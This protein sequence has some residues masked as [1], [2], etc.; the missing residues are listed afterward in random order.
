MRNSTFE[1]VELAKLT[2]L[3]TDGTHQTPTYTD[4]GIPFLRVTDLTKSNESKK[5]ISIDEHTELTKRCNPIKGDILYSKNGTIGVAKIIDWDYEFSIFVS[6]ALL[7]P[8]K[9]LIIPKYLEILLNSEEAL[10]RAKGFS[11]SGTVTNLHLIDIKRLQI[12]LPTLLI[13]EEIVAEIEGYQK[14]IDGAK[15]VVEN[16]KPKIDIDPDWEMVE[17]G[18]IA[19][20]EYGFTEKAKDEGDARFIRITDIGTDGK[21]IKTDAKYID[22]TKEA[23]KSIVKRN[24][25]LLARTGATYGKTMIYEENYPAVF[26]SFLMRLNFDTNKVFPKYYWAFAQSENYIVQAASLMTGGGQPQFNGNA[27]VKIKLPLPSIETQSKI[28]SQIEKEQALVNA[29]KQLIEIFEQKIKD[30]IAKVWGADKSQPVV[31]EENEQLTMAAE[32]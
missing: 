2:T 4:S 28:V 5:F 7:K 31:Y 26:A 23:K 29:N 11:K 30:R 12:P 1:Y 22:L 14:I 3:I 10:V 17:L 9:E 16:Y 18:E 21:L 25:I 8:I 20:P 15:A 6:L 24:D 13:Q 27:V 19:K 32:I